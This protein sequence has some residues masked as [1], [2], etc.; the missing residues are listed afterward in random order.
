MRL[1]TEAAVP[2]IIRLIWLAALL[3]W[4]DPA[5][6]IDYRRRLGMSM[7]TFRRDVRALCRL[8]RYLEEYVGIQCALLIYLWLTGLM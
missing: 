7:Y 5:C 3:F 2:R 8:G 6:F 4:D 1:N